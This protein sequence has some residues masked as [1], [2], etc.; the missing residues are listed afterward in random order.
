VLSIKDW[1]NADIEINVESLDLDI[2]E[3]VKELESRIRK[4][5][6]RLE[7]LIKLNNVEKQEHV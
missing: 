5:E 2:K 4:L 6:T 7:E 1:D 3:R